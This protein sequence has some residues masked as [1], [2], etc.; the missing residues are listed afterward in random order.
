MLRKCDHSRAARAPVA[1]SRDPVR[2][3]CPKPSGR[4]GKGLGGGRKR[5]VRGRSCSATPA[6]GAGGRTGAFRGAPVVVYG[7]DLDPGRTPALPPA[8]VG[9]VG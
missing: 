5:G 3:P 4:R 8:R 7:P 1:S 6:C 9:K 2:R